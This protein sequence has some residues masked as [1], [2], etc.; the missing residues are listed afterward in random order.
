MNAMRS[1]TFGDEMRGHTV[2]VTLNW[3]SWLFGVNVDALPSECV[4][5]FA[6]G[7]VAAL[8]WRDRCV[9]EPTPDAKHPLMH[10]FVPSKNW[11]GLCAQWL[12]EGWCGEGE[13]DYMHERAEVN[14]R[15]VDRDGS[16]VAG[17]VRAIESM[18]RERSDGR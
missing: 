17:V 2:T 7:P 3:S 1:K 16:T 4:V 6:F 14:N 11:P 8:W 15:R 13:E 10:K 5:V 9:V 12:G 18:S